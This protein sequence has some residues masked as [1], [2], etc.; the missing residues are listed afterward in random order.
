MFSE[1]KTTTRVSSR[2]MDELRKGLLAITLG[3][4][5]APGSYA[6]SLYVVNEYDKTLS[7]IDSSKNT[8]VAT[9]SVNDNVNS[10]VM[11][12]DSSKVY[13]STV[14]ANAI[15]ILN[16]QTNS[17]T[18][19]ISLPDGPSALVVSPDG[20]SLYAI[21]R[22][23]NVY[24]ISTASDTVSATLS[25]V[26]NLGAQ[27]SAAFSSDGSLL[28]V[29]TGGIGPAVLQYFDI[30]TKVA[31]TVSVSGS[32][33]GSS[34]AV[35]ANP[36]SDV[37]YVGCSGSSIYAVDSKNNFSTTQ[38]VA[39][40]QASGGAMTPNGQTL[41]F[42]TESS[43]ILAID[44]TTL[45][46][47]QTIPDAGFPWGVAITAD[48]AHAYVPNILTDTVS[49]I[50]T[51]TN[52]IVATIP[53]G[54]SPDLVVGGLLSV[55]FAK[56]TPELLVAPKRSAYSVAASFTLG[57]SAP[58]LSP[59]TQ[60]LTLTIGS[61]SVTVPA[62]SIKKPN[63]KIGLYTYDGVVNGEKIG[64]VLTGNGSGPW[65]ILVVGTDA[66]G[67]LAASV[68]VSL[69]IGQSSGTANVKPIVVNAVQSLN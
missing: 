34:I 45:T 33:P 23:G 64:L 29:V 18:G 5:M 56:Y 42:T 38:I 39:G 9:V 69:A 24:L 3:L 37:V 68:P 36:K 59:T 27:Q 49:V 35:V 1:E 40:S 15:E 57:T 19:S 62:G 16:T 31:G 63:A 11:S 30:A 26:F 41:Y 10:M 58:A 44:P 52:A 47:K 66:F 43:G 55:P 17:F 67:T 28:F 4:A 48:G 65:G 8:V 20:T 53:V 32:R 13:I 25:N 60:S 12:K 50:D 51:S 22:P 14:N 46:I 2:L 61:F 6:D 7:V 54:V 21:S